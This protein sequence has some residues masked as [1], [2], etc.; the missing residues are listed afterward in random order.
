MIVISLI[1]Y[2]IVVILIVV[3]KYKKDIKRMEELE[4]TLEQYYIHREQRLIKE[5][6]SRIKAEENVSNKEYR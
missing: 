2:T 3:R 4:R 1:A 5:L 6:K